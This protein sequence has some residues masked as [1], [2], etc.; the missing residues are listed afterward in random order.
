LLID[1]ENKTYKEIIINPLCLNTSSPV[2]V[3]TPLYS[4]GPGFPEQAA[5]TQYELLSGLDWGSINSLSCYALSASSKVLN[6]LNSALGK[7]S[8]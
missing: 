7:P 2:A 3:F 5:S 8:V 1:N 6:D 4:R